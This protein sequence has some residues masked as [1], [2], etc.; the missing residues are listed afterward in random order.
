[1]AYR[2]SSNSAQQARKRKAHRRGDLTRNAALTGVAL[3]S[4]SLAAAG[5]A[6]FGHHRSL[7]LAPGQPAGPRALQIALIDVAP[8]AVAW[9]DPRVAVATPGPHIVRVAVRSIPLP[10][11]RPE[12]FAPSPPPLLTLAEGELTGS[13][14]QPA[15]E[16]VD[17]KSAATIVASA[18]APSPR[19]SP[20][21]KSDTSDFDRLKLPNSGKPEFGR[22]EGEEALAGTMAHEKAVEALAYTPVTQSARRQEDPIRTAT[23]MSYAPS[24]EMVFENDVTGSIGNA[25]R[26]RF[27]ALP[28]SASAPSPRPSAQSKSDVSDFDHLKLPNSGKPE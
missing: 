23:L 25:A 6:L 20:Q 12:R 16:A 8:P 15:H 4:V 13:I 14:G 19:P 22:G 28:T 17:T 18:L 21:S 26:E 24:R 3:A 9:R 7:E 10:R 2:V 27:A 11:E 1:M 5:A